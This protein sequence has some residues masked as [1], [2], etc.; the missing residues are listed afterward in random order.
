M[1]VGRIDMK[2]FVII[3]NFVA[4]IAIFLFGS[5]SDYADSIF[6]HHKIEVLQAQSVL[7]T[8]ALSVF[9]D[10]ANVKK[11]DDSVRLMWYLKSP[12]TVSWLPMLAFLTLLVNA[13]LIM[14]FWKRSSPKSDHSTGTLGSMPEMKGFQPSAE[15]NSSEGGHKSSL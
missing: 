13:S 5:A 11:E 3:F 9:L 15:L 12:G 6:L 1:I 8:N 10:T 7:N 2:T 4:A 14:L